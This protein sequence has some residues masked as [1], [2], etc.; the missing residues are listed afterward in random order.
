MRALAFLLNRPIA[1]T[2]SFLAFVLLGIVAM[3]QIP[4]S[5]LPS[6]PIGNITIKAVAEG[7]SSRKLEDEV[8]RSIRYQMMQISKV[9]GISSKTY[10]G[11]GIVELSF[12]IGTD[13]DLVLFEVNEQLDRVMGILPRNI[14]RPVVMQIG[15]SDIPIM[16]LNLTQKEQ[17]HWTG[18]EL[19]RFA[20]DVVRRRLE[21]IPGVAFVDISG[22]THDELAITPN[23]ARME[24]MGITI[25][26]IVNLLTNRNNKATTVRLQQ[27]EQEFQIVFPA[28]ANT[29][30]QL[31]K[32]EIRKDNRTVKLHEVCRIDIKTKPADGY[33]LYNGLPAI[34]MA[35]IGQ[36]GSRVGVVKEGIQDVVSQMT[37]NYP[38]MEFSTV[39]D[40]SEFLELTISNLVVTLVLGTLLAV[41][42]VFLF[43]G[44]TRLPI[45]IGLSIPVS[46]LISI[47]FFNILGISVNI[48]SLSG[49]ILGIGMM[50]D[51][52]IIV[53]DNISRRYA[54][55]HDLS[56]AVIEGPIEVLLP[57]L[58]SVLT[59]TAVFVP[60]IFLS[61]IS[62]ALFY[63]QAIAI[64]V[65]LFVSLIVSIIL[66]PLYYKLLRSVHPADST[67]ASRIFQ[68]FYERGFTFF[69]KHQKTL[70]L[71][72]A[73][74]IVLG[75]ISLINSKK[76]KIPEVTRTNAMIYVDWNSPITPQENYKRTQ[77]LISIAKE[78][79]SQ[80]LAW[81]GRQQYFLNHLNDQDAR[82]TRCFFAFESVNN[83]LV[84]L[85][86]MQNWLAL[87]YPKAL[88]EQEI[89]PNLFD[90][91]FLD[92]EPELTLQLQYSKPEQALPDNSLPLITNIKKALR[93]L[94]VKDIAMHEQIH[95]NVDPQR[96]DALEIIPQQLLTNI[97]LQLNN[98]KVSTI[99][100]GIDVKDIV[101]K[102]ESLLSNEWANEVYVTNG[103]NARIALCKLGTEHRTV[104]WNAIYANKQGEYI[105]L[106]IQELGDAN[107][108]WAADQAKKVLQGNESWSVS[109]IGSATKQNAQFKEMMLVLLVSLGLLF[110]ILAAQF[111][112]VT[113][114]L[115]ILLEIPIN[116]VGVTLMLFL[117]GSS[118]NII[119]M[120][121]IVVM[122]GIVINDSI[123]KVDTINRLRK[124]GVPV[125]DAVHKAGQIRLRP[126]IMT[127]LTTIFALIPFIFGKGLGNEIQKPMALAIIGGMGLGTVVSILFLPFFYKWLDGA[128]NYIKKSLCRR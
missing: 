57:L 35:V 15:A 84:T 23:R 80:Q 44:S 109:A 60:L 86:S 100:Q 56:L 31:R 83:W 120:I 8:I 72:C 65:G 22:I 101:I 67:F 103:G 78:K 50:I 38:Q 113:Q 68:K 66:I 5:L 32:M 93:P 37:T 6:I 33:C 75:A 45:V 102:G 42:M 87:N 71:L 27:G 81:A 125:H 112:S 94:Q 9:E 106:A 89:V 3:Q 54:I 76:E 21:Q 7:Y 14:T 47:L 16:Y 110:F 126:I 4:V 2:M 119:S 88:I 115:I 20:N 48:I 105:P 61:G 59:T 46:L 25:S 114:P 95:F 62:G 77:Q 90:Y 53:V 19:S 69:E 111:E 74:L 41:A 116:I 58:S 79:T 51:N 99:S 40:Q 98:R 29:L 96:L 124:D 11:L 55:T 17:G 82:E 30:P 70:M 92:N 97:E 127:S 10:D 26:D 85:D 52:A 128:T 123:L 49:L 39:N 13:M 43:I 36:D 34:S 28:L 63:E 107:A 121:G 118:I 108:Q 117:F 122:A 24:L 18:T 104:R 91:I 12:P 1:V 64:S 73:L